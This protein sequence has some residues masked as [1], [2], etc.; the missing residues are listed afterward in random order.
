MQPGTKIEPERVVAETKAWLE[1]AVIGLNL[2]PFAKGVHARGQ[3]RYVVSVAT[4]ELALLA[5]LL[6]EF[7]TLARADPE[8]LDT[9]LL[10]HPRMLADFN[11]FNQFLGNAEEA[12]A[13]AGH[14]GVFQLASFHPQYQF[15]GTS[16]KD[17]TNASNRSPYPMLHILREASVERAV[18]AFPDAQ[19]IYERNLATLRSLGTRNWR[20]LMQKCRDDALAPGGAPEG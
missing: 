3:I 2:C 17:V 8:V 1:R 6:D 16:P 14:E 15:A 7:E 10:I 9:T 18:A 12:L 13:R 20:L 4:E 19:S 5:A 11:A